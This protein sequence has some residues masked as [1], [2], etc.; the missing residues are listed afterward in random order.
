MGMK[1]PGVLEYRLRFWDLASLSYS[2]WPTFARFVAV[3]M[4]PAFSVLHVQAPLF[5]HV[6]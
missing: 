3:G 2:N 6:G 5:H 4:P 1:K